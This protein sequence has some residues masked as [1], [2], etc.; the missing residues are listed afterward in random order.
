MGEHWHDTSLYAGQSTALSQLPVTLIII[1]A[2]F[3]LCLK[4]PPGFLELFPV[5]AETLLAAGQPE[6][7]FDEYILG[8]CPDEELL[9]ALDI[10]LQCVNPLPTLRPTMLQVVK[11][12]AWMRGDNAGWT[13]GSSY[14]GVSGFLTKSGSEEVVTSNSISSQT[15]GAHTPVPNC[16]EIAPTSENSITGPSA[17]RSLR[18]TQLAQD[19]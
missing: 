17:H 2:F 15:S 11:M 19:R 18:S 5:Q 12:L 4:S 16:K 9:T 8:T 10:T 3:C 7:I 6:D 14:F 13:S 1:F